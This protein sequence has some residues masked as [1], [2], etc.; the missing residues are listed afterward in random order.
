MSG[1]S[2][3]DLVERKRTFAVK[4][5]T[6]S[7]EVTYQPN[8]LTP[9]K[10]KRINEAIGEDAVSAADLLAEIMTGWDLV[11]PF[12]DG[13]DMAIK[14]GEPVPITTEHLEH[15]P[16]PYL[17]HILNSIIEDANPDPKRRTRSSGR[18]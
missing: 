3:A 14:A 10:M 9:A 7:L 13:T 8:A 1:M 16:G 15:M 4:F 12:A 6:G 18:S 11:G 5:P 2:F 17:G